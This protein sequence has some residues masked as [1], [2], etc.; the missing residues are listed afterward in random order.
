MR[1]SPNHICC[2]VDFSGVAP[3]VLNYGRALAR[4]YDAK[5][6]ACHIVPDAALLASHASPAFISQDTTV[7]RLEDATQSLRDLA[8]ECDVQAT[9]LVSIGHA[10]DEIPILAGDNNIDLVIAATYG[11]SGI[12]RFLVGSVTARLLKTLDCPLLVLPPHSKEKPSR[13]WLPIKR[14]LVGCDFSFGS[15]LAI[16]YALS[17]AQEF[18]AEIHL[19]HVIKPYHQ[20]ESA[21][22]PY[23]LP[24]EGP[25]GSGLGH[26][27]EGVS[28]DAYERQRTRLSKI[29]SRL[30]AMVPQ[31]SRNWCTPSTCVRQGEPY[32]ELINYARTLDMDMM[33]LGIH[34]HSL[35]EKFLVG[36]TTERVIGRAECPVLAVRE[37][38]EE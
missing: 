2:A 10:G 1:I 13:Q 17:L 19:V 16:H 11:G 33:V 27:K 34:G 30:A 20:I 35:L 15:D 29:E 32:Q 24:E 22:P 28:P 26:I 5:L 12:K 4:E 25:A 8:M 6:F 7:R 38:Q 3:L 23:L 18:E 36:S 14:V 9:P 21:V 37:P 31:D